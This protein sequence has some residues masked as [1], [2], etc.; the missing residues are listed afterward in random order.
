M[1]KLSPKIAA[2]L[3]LAS[4]NMKEQSATGIVKLGPTI[5][6]A[7]NFDLSEGP[8]KAVSGGFFSHLFRSTTGFAMVGKGKKGKYEGDIVVAIRG[9]A[10]LRD[11][12]TD[13]HCGL[14]GADN[15]EMVHLGFNKT[16]LTMKSAIRER[17]KKCQP[18]SGSKVTVHCV[19]HS[20]GGALATLVAD[21]IKTEFKHSVNL[22]TFGSPR[23]G[24]AGFARKTSCN[25][26]NIFR[27]THGADPV[28]NV[29]LWPFTHVPQDGSEYRL[30]GSSGFRGSAHKMGVEGNP[31][32]MNTANHD[33]WEALQIQS[34]STLSAVRLKYENR[35]Q[36]SH[37]GQWAD[38]IGAA[39]ITLL[40]DAGYYTAVMAQAA[41]GTTFTFY[42]LVAKTLDKIVKASVKL[43]DQTLGL[44]GHM[45]AFAG[46]AAYKL[47]ELTYKI[48]RW[49]FD[50]TL[51][52]LYRSA[53]TAIDGIF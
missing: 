5:D 30:D 22:Y 20:L 1:A 49:V 42:D 36:A 41:I 3:A 50:K 27:C 37:S 26:D 19:G 31:G 33:S 40:K 45:L 39:L 9:T 46:K 6:R 17:V 48:I 7:F 16:F 47:S 2:S 13:A 25:L 34:S 43:A 8:V 10:S 11:G 23:V 15:G 4:Y 44:L 51:N 32:Y 21:W 24:L 29:P 38:K 53:R 14:T 12:I 18:S 35:H 28:P 52:V